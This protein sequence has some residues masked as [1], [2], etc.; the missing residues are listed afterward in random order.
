MRST[1]RPV[2][3]TATFLAL[4]LSGCLL[5]P[6]HAGPGAVAVQGTATAGPTCPVVTNPPNPACA[7]RPVAGAVLVFSNAAGKEVAR[8]TSSA[9]GTFRVTLDPGSYRLTAQPVQGLMGTPAPLDV[10]VVAGVP[11]SDLQVSYDTGIR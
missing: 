4:L 1:S 3:T 5:L 9:D 8:A 6:G 2:A 11:I 7:E 10:E